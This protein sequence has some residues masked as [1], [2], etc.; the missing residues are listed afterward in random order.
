[1]IRPNIS[2]DEKIQIRDVIWVGRISYS[3]KRR[4]TREEDKIKEILKA[5]N[6]RGEREVKN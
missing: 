6:V 1:M 5:T 3:G 4:E 2:R